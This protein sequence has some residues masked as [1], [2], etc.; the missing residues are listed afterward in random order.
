MKEPEALTIFPITGFIADFSA[1]EHRAFGGF[2]G[3]QIL[4]DAMS[5]RKGLIC[6]ANTAVGE[7]NSYKTKKT[8]LMAVF[9]ALAYISVFVINIP[10]YSFLK[11]EPKDVIIVI[12]GFLFGP[13]A[14]LLMSVTVS[15]IELVTISDTGMIGAVMNVISTAAFVVPAAV[16]YKKKH[17]MSG[18]VIGLITGTAIMVIMMLLWNYLI[19]PI[20]METPREVVAGML[21]TIFLPFNLL[22]GSINGTVTLLVYKPLVNALR[23]TSMLPPSEK[24]AE[25]KSKKQLIGIYAA[26]AFVLVTCVM[27]VLVIN[28]TVSLGV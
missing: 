9:C 19:T 17:T 4:A 5:A 14:A 2:S 12:G 8:V 20:Y 11:Y 26:V 3:L 18:A 10:V 1:P 24:T 22:K 7:R 13:A 15:L 6:M 23:K 16:I 27:F 21:P 25:I 28:G